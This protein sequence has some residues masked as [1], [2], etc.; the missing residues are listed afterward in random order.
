MLGVRVRLGIDIVICVLR[1]NFRTT[2]YTKP[3]TLY[4]R[5]ITRP[6]PSTCGWVKGLASE[7]RGI[8][9]HHL[10]RFSGSAL[11]SLRFLLF[12]SAGSNNVAF[13]KKTIVAY[14]IFK[15][16]SGGFVRSA[17][18][19]AVGDLLLRDF[20]RVIGDRWTLRLSGLLIRLA[21]RYF[22]WLLMWFSW[23]DCGLVF[24]P[25]SGFHFCCLHETSKF[26]GY[27]QDNEYLFSLQFVHLF[28]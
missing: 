23:L 26:Y 14:G 18:P 16:T 4:V 27:P 1:E 12:H 25:R 2:I 8:H 15:T 7:T 28:L 19:V 20:G 10:M 24:P 5:A 9:Y 22:D 17:A 21:P 11:A 6:F 13:L 3:T